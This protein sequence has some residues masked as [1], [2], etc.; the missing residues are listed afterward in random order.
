MRLLADGIS[1]ALVGI[2]ALHG[3][4]ALRIWWPLRD[5]TALARAV[6]GRAGI[7]KMPTPAACW[8]M[9]MVLL[10]AALW[11]QFP[12]DSG[13]LRG[14]LVALGLAVMSALCFARGL[15]A[16]VP[17]LRRS[18]SEEPFATFDRRYYAPLCLVLGGSVGLVLLTHLI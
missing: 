15:G 16:Y 7:I 14:A 12:L 1:V 13:G 3:L 2:A 8:A 10:A 9:V 6:V 17:A 4:W 18:R 5:E 11:L